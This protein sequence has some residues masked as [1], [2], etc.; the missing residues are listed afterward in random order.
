MDPGNWATDI[1]AGSKFGYA[2]IWVV[3]LSNFMA[4]LLQSH[5]ARLGLVTDKDIAQFSRS[6][7][8]HALNFF[9]G[10]LL[11]LPLLLP[12]LPKFWEWLLV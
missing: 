11:R 6:Y 4:I 5:S 12:T 10:F 3:V 8:P 2:L 7:Y 1:E 9:T